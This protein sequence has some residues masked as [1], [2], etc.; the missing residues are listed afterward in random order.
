[1]FADCGS[2]AQLEI[3]IY[4]SFSAAKAT[5]RFVLFPNPSIRTSAN[6][7]SFLRHQKFTW[8]RE[9]AE[10]EGKI[11]QRK[12]ASQIT[13]R[14]DERHSSN[15]KIVSRKS[16]RCALAALGLLA[17]TLAFITPKVI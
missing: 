9:I 4:R 10:K 11:S 12:S 3:E 15:M 5:I 8:W 14:K 6:D 2:P 16:M 7:R 13:L 1:M 17:V